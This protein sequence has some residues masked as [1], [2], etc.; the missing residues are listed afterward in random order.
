M[1]NTSLKVERTPAPVRAQVLEG[2]SDG[3]ASVLTQIKFVTYKP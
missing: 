3:Q 1:T 2:K